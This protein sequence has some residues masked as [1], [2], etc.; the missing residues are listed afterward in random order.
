MGSLVKKGQIVTTTIG[1][2]GVVTWLSEQQVKIKW[3]LSDHGRKVDPNEKSV[4]YPMLD[5]QKSIESGFLKF[6]DSDDP[7]TAFLMRKYNVNS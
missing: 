4:K 3:T 2:C 7:N 6:T 5:I 1:A